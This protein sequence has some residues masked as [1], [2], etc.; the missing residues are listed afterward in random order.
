MSWPFSRDHITTQQAE[1][2]CLLE[3]TRTHPGAGCKLLLGYGQVGG[4]GCREHTYQA[5]YHQRVANHLVHLSLPSFRLRIHLLLPC[6]HL[7][8]TSISDSSSTIDIPWFSKSIL[9]SSKTICQT[10]HF[11]Y[12]LHLRHRLIPS[13]LTRF[14]FCPPP[15]PLFAT[16]RTK[17]ILSDCVVIITI[18]I[19]AFLPLGTRG[20]SVLTRLPVP[21]FPHFLA[22]CDTITKPF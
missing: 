13:R 14:Q 5:T 1:R 18:F 8:P 3:G 15:L 2:A 16:A 11:L 17:A 4:P 6:Y 10:N 12:I 22:S 9:L 7:N 19:P 21:F 20:S